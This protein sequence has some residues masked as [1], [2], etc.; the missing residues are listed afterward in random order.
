M[1]ELEFL[2]NF[3]DNLQKGINSYKKKILNKRSVGGNECHINAILSTIGESNNK[4]LSA[5]KIVTTHNGNEE[6]LL[7]DEEHE[8]LCLI[9]ER[10]NLGEPGTE[11]VHLNEEVQ[12]VMDQSQQATHR[13][14]MNSSTLTVGYHHGCL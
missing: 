2:R 3:F 1:S 8:D 14:V 11:E 6:I 10:E 13:R 7:K 4:I 5:M 9:D 12:L